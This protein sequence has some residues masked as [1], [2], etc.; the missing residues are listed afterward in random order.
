LSPA[1]FL[2]IVIAL[3]WLRRIGPPLTVLIATRIIVI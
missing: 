1:F 3:Y 2:P